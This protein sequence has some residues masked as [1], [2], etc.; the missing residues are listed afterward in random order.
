MSMLPST[1]SLNGLATETGLDRRTVA[2]YLA[3]TKPAGQRTHGPVFL[4]RTLV[5]ALREEPTEGDLGELSMRILDVVGTEL[6]PDVIQAFAAKLVTSQD[7]EEQER[8]SLALATEVAFA[9]VVSLYE[10][11]DR[12]DCSTLSKK[13]IRE[14]FRNLGDSDVSFEEIA[15]LALPSPRN[16]PSQSP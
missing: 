8:L 13:R 14:V 7:S 10:R 12:I 3:N 5:A 4:M 11:S 1:W 15:K 9:L 2:N 16:S 6:K